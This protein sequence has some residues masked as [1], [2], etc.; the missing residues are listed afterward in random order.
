MTFALRFLLRA[1]ASAFSSTLAHARARDRDPCVTQGP[2]AAGSQRQAGKVASAA[3]LLE[4]VHQG[5]V[6]RISFVEI[7]DLC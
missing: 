3:V 1:S 4:A 7:R 2:G 6:G 5:R